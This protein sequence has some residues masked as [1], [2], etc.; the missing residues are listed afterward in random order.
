ML[1]G[2]DVTDAQGDDGCAC[3]L[4]P[5]SYQQELKGTMKG[6]FMAGDKSDLTQR[7]GEHREVE[8][9]ALLVVAQKAARLIRGLVNAP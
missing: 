4:F 1:L 7:R 8:S 5:K 3:S 9:A 6:A 2:R